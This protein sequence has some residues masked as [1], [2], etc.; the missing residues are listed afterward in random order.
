MIKHYLF[1][2]VFVLLIASCSSVN[3]VDQILQ[4]VSD[5]ASLDAALTEL[6]GSGAAPGLSVAVVSKG[7]PVYLMGFG[8]AD[9]SESNLVQAGSGFN[10]WSVAKVFTQLAVLD[11]VDVGRI[12]LD[13]P[14]CKYIAWL[15]VREC[16]TSAAQVD[17]RTVRM[18]MDHTAGVP[19][20]GLKLYGET[21]FD[22]DE[23]PSQKAIARRLIDANGR[24]STP[25]GE[26]R[27]SNTHYLLLA[28]IV[29][30]VS[31]QTFAEYV[32]TR[33]L[34]PLG[35]ANTGYRYLPGLPIM[36]GSHPADTTSFFA[37]FY[38]DKA[39][40]VKTKQ[41]G[42]YWFNNVYNSSLGSTGLV[43]NGNDMAKFMTAM[44]SCLR[45]AEGP[46]ALRSCN[47]ITEAESSP[48]TKSPARGVE[49]LEQKLGWFVY[50]TD[51]GNSFAHGGSG[52][53]YTAMLQLFPDKELGIFV[54]ANDSYFDRRGGLAVTTAV[55][56]VRW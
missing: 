32:Q 50:P 33:V 12:Q 31:G 43:S 29:E 22:S 30:H 40:A 23:I 15:E 2:C 28:A 10:L 54:V 48:V 37:F 1:R 11:L 49:G 16:Q 3:S 44:L 4:P 36:S 25:D 35:L 42:R 14:V 34:E 41:S 21:Q 5:V 8:H 17:A 18:L 7:E 47:R 38:V 27:Y 53:G 51:L 45:G 24:W 13:D 6:V 56:R 39:R 9:A 46:I 19:D 52:M 26:S 20:L 55:S